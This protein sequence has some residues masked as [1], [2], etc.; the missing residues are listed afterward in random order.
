MAT[1]AILAF[2]RPQMLVSPQDEINGAVRIYA[3]YLTARNLTI[4]LMLLAALALRAR[5][6][7]NSLV[8]LTAFVQAFDAIVDVAEGRWVIVPGVAVLAVLFFFA[9]ARLSGHPFWKVQ[10]WR[11]GDATTE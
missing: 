2:F 3:G 5:N 4:A 1:G 11:L 7:L 10:A 6:M 8:L 9:A